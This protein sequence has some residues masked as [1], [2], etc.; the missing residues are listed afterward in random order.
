MQT[1]LSKVGP[2]QLIIARERAVLGSTNNAEGAYPYVSGRKCRR[3]K[4][5]ANLMDK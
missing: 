1:T 3:D 5:L 2:K 4:L